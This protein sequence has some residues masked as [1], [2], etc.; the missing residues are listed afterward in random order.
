MDTTSDLVINSTATK[1]ISTVFNWVR[2]DR[3]I[4]LCGGSVIDSKC[5][6][7]LTFLEIL[8]CICTSALRKKILN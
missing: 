2:C 8:C 3:S 6:Q 5:T 4:Y 1:Q 7:N